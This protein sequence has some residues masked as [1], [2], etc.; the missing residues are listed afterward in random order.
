MPATKEK[1]SQQKKSVPDASETL[2]E[3]TVAQ[4]DASSVPVVTSSYRIPGKLFRFIPRDSAELYKIIPLKLE[5][6]TLYVGAVDPSN[7]DARD[8]LNFITTG[9]DLQY[10][11]QK[12]E[13]D[14]F[15]I[16]LG[17]YD[18][19]DLN[20]EE[21]LEQ[22]VEE[23]EENVLLDLGDEDADSNDTT[24]QEEAPVIKLVSTILAQAVAKGVSDVHVEPGEKIAVVRYRLDG[25]LQ[26]QMQFSKKIL[27]SFVARI[28][29]LA[30][31]RIDER[32][33][34]QDGRF[35]SRIKDNRVDFR[36]AVFPTVSG[37]KV[38][39]RVLDK[40]KG[41]RDLASVGLEGD[42]YQSI[43]RAVKRPYG[44]VLATGPTGAGKTTTLYAI[45]SMM[46]R[47]NQSIV[48]L[49]DPVEYRLEGVNQS[50][51]RPEIGYT[52]A[53][54][55]RSV[56][57]ADPDQIFVGEIR[58]K[59]TASLAV[60]A[61]LTGHLVYSTLHTNSAIGAVSR[62]LNFGVDPFLLAP[63]LSLVIGQR[64]VRRLD[65]AG[66]EMP[67]NAGM[68]THL[69]KQFADLPQRYR[70]QIPDFTSFREPVPSEENPSG[71]RGRVGVFEVFE[72]DAAIRSII[73]NNPSEATLH[74]AAR[75][76]GFMTMGEDALIKGLKGIIPF[77]EAM[78]VGNEGVLTDGGE[79]EQ[80]PQ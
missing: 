69:E 54:G 24:I 72:V 66:K 49:E 36:V 41:L 10:Q 12:I 23:G 18:N 4:K 14:L 73:F 50:S 19:A 57:R 43:L 30:S 2:K 34:P 28:K 58:D 70:S 71:M 56:L 55:L 33:R 77:S 8:A 59:E 46:D 3:A 35:S 44:L 52:F 51:I 13:E 32:R 5:G 80:A 22:L 37:E 16:L 65:G 6:A 29:I 1:E 53:T 67:V 7:L 74:E 17:Q 78:K 60:Q 45:L 47:V 75:K 38:I 63:I 76:N 15:Q 48:S 62:L 11:V 40:E 79:E 64:M 31:L 61:A 9:Q 25:I 42:A 27:D 20:M 39:L 26:D 68:K 21:T